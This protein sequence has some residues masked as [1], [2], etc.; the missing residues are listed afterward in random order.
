M[1]LT[2]M[3]LP[4]DEELKVVKMAKAG[5]VQAMHLLI[6]SITPLIKQEASRYA[7]GTMDVFELVNEGVLGA[8]RALATFDETLG[9]RFST[10]AVGLHGMVKT[11]IRDAVAHSHIIQQ[12]TYYKK[13]HGSIQIDNL[14]SPI[15][16]AFG[17]NLTLIDIVPDKSNDMNTPVEYD[18]VEREME[19]ID[20]HELIDRMPDGIE[21]TTIRKVANGLTM[22]EIASETKCSRMMP[23]RNTEKAIAAITKMINCRS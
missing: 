5:C 19:T 13:K 15:S 11:Y 23:Q 20:I 21:K 16:P 10:H 8:Y 9:F 14:N 1:E 17:K 22:R 6:N 3:E 7:G 2:Y 18:M 12:S 4:R